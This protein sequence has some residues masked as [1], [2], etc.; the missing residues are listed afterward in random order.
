[1]IDSEK[2]WDFARISDLRNCFKLR[3]SE[4]VEEGDWYVDGD[5]GLVYWVMWKL[6]EEI[7]ERARF[8]NWSNQNIEIDNRKKLIYK[9]LEIWVVRESMLIEIKI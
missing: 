3:I 9:C 4:L 5:S 2:I 6:R 8:G 1:M 7:V